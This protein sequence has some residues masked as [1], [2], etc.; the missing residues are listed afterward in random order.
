VRQHDLIVLDT[1]PLIFDL[2]LGVSTNLIFEV[3]GN[4][5]LCYYLLADGIDP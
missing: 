5:Y 3:N 2:L 1:S 4:M